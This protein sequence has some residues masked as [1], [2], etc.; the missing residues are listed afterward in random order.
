M[1]SRLFAALG[2][3]RSTDEVAGANQIFEKYE[4]HV[5]LFTPDYPLIE[6][7]TR[8]PIQPAKRIS[9]ELVPTASG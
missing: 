2:G 6:P 1:S 4:E 9:S 5:H 7:R 8:V 3:R